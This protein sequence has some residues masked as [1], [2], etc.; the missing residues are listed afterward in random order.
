MAMQVPVKVTSQEE[1]NEQTRWDAWKEAAQRGHTGG[2][3]G[4]LGR[5]RGVGGMERE[6][7]QTCCFS[8]SLGTSVKWCS[9][10]VMFAFS[11]TGTAAEKWGLRSAGVDGG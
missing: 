11:L 7:V 9:R 5:V 2:G 8:P 4:A 1:V 3:A 6:V 10:C